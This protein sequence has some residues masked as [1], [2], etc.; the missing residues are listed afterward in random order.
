ME[1]KKIIA[2]RRP[3]F[4]CECPLNVSVIRNLKKGQCGRMDTIGKSG[5]WSVGGM[6]PDERCLIEVEE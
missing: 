3:M 1:I 5:S 2:D 4:C 6:V